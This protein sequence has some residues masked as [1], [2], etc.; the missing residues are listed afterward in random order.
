MQRWGYRSSSYQVMLGSLEC[1]RTWLVVTSSGMTLCVCSPISR[2]GQRTVSSDKA[3]SG[4]RSGSTGDSFLS[5]RALLCDY[6]LRTWP[7][8]GLNWSQNLMRYSIG[9]V[10]NKTPS[11][12]YQSVFFACQFS[13]LPELTPLLDVVIVVAA[14][15]SSI[16]TVTGHGNLKIH[17]QYGSLSSSWK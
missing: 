11:G 17:Q 7:S 4:V 9:T 2:N 3:D 8:S 5:G 13:L 12:R 15:T 1:H 14:V 10:C 6:A 16:A